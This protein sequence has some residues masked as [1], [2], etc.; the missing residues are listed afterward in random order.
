MAGVHDKM[1]NASAVNTNGQYFDNLGSNVL[2]YIRS[3]TFSIVGF[4]RGKR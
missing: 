2:L 3:T 4:G 1:Y